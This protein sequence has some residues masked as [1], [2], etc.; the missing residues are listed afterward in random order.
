MGA[1]YWLLGLLAAA[2]FACGNNGG[3][4]DSD[5]NGSGSN[6]PD[7]GIGETV[8]APPYGGQC[9]VGGSVQC[10]DCVDNDM[11]GKI[12]GFDPECSGPADDREDSF[13]TGIPGDNIDATMQDCFFD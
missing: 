6:G 7:G 1:R 3:S 12:D 5:A 4:G 10:S 8:D 11:D 2:V 9:T 13:S